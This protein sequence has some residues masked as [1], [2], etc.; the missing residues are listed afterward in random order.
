MSERMVQVGRH[1]LRVSIRGEGRPVLLMNG[2]G[3]SIA[4]WDALH[5][6]LTGLKVI[7][8]DAPGVGR[9]SS[10]SA[11]YRMSVLA[12]LAAELLDVLGHDQV[13][14]VGY[15][16]GGVLAQQFARN[17]PERVR[18][19]VLC[20]TTP[21]WGGLAGEV[22]SLLAV[23]TP[24]RYYSKRAY[25]LT[26]G[27]LAGGAAEADP[28]FLARTAAARVADPPSIGGYWLQLMAAWSW[29]SLPWL[30]Q[31]EHP[32]LLITGADDRLVP[33]VNSELIASRLRR[34]RLVRIDGWG[35]YVMLDR[36]SGAG[37]AILDF[38][39]ADRAEDSRAWREGR[40]VT[41]QEAGVAAAAHR[42]ALTRLYWHHGVYRRWHT[43]ERSTQPGA[44]RP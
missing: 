11:P 19:L 8:F 18:R 3:A 15:S 40:E 10:P 1:R 12:D 36:A 43:R 30:H 24:V 16:F 42:N 7:S 6:D 29:S 37:A 44:V 2:L 35:H 5:E 39:D 14:V 13:D 22:T 38:L 28:A 23:M 21:G 25:A 20:A 9:S 27:A 41:R 4:M 32:T 31:L 26:A 17:H 34:A 33:A